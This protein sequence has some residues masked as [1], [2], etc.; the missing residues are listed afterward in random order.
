M[1]MSMRHTTSGIEIQA[2]R[3]TPHRKVAPHGWER[4]KRTLVWNIP[5]LGSS[6]V[7]PR[8]VRWSNTRMVSP[9]GTPADSES[10]REVGA[11]RRALQLHSS[12]EQETHNA[13]FAVRAM[14]EWMDFIWGEKEIYVYI[15]RDVD[16]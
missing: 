6:S 8:R 2:R 15:D 16:E 1:R 11:G 13:I 14:D 10:T 4:E 5:S 12:L 3:D 9:R 7:T